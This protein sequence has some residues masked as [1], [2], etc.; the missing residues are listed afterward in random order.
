[1]SRRCQGNEGTCHGVV[2]AFAGYDPCKV[3]EG[4]MG[5]CERPAR[6]R[7]VSR[8]PSVK[9]P[10]CRADLGRCISR[11]E[12]SIAW[13]ADFEFFKESEIST[14]GSRFARPW[15]SAEVRMGARDSL[16]LDAAISCLSYQG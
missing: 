5:Y 8:T 13:E 15:L 2:G 1:M 16:G 14:G 11:G 12:F 6:C 9:S 7:P 3:A 10:E 4:S